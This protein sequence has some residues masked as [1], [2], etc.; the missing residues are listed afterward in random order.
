M[1]RLFSYII[2]TILLV[3]CKESEQERI[4]RLVNEWSG[5]VIQFPDSICLR[6]F[7]NDTVITKYTK[8]NFTYTILNYVDTIGCVSCRLQLP[9]WK[10]MMNEIDSIYPNKVNCLMVFN[11]QGKNL[12]IRQLKNNQFDYFVF[13]DEKDT[14]NKMNNFLSEENFTTFLLDKDDRILAIG[15][16]VLS[17]RVRELYFNIISEKNPLESID[18]Q[19]LTTVSLSRN[20]VDLGNFSWKLKKDV[21]IQISNIGEFPL[22]ISDVIASCGCTKVEYDKSPIPPGKSTILNI[23]YQADHPE[24]FDK[25]VTVYCNI[26]NSYLQV[27]IRGNAE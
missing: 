8:E 27:K 10:E 18:K 22:V 13:I 25:T 14:L 3:S 9:R 26:Q 24:Y 21:E 19:L 23:I 2:F 20:R 17:P 16:P 7:R 5:K 1:M 4:T 15:N 11:P 6:S 12:L